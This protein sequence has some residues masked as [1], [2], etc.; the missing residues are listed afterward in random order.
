MREKSLCTSVRRALYC[1]ISGGVPHTKQVHGKYSFTL[2][3]ND[4]VSVAD[5]AML[6][7]RT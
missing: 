1:A 7:Y 4:A 5:I 3:N 6:L 2:Y